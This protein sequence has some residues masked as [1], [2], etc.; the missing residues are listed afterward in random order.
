MGILKNSG[1]LGPRST[2]GGN[3]AMVKR[4]HHQE[5][6]HIFEQNFVGIYG[7]A[8]RVQQDLLG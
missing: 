1:G 5:L 3:T 4:E 2:E 7:K 8:E 6:D